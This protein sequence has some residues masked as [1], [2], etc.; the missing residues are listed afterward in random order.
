MRR[1]ES[2]ERVVQHF[3]GVFVAGEEHERRGEI[4]GR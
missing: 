4:R 3:G 1:R 2:P